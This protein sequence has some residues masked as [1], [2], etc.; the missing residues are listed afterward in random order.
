M[1][2]TLSRR[3]IWYGRELFGVVFKCRIRIWFLDGASA[4]LQRSFIIC[5]TACRSF[6][7]VN[8]D[9]KTDPVRPFKYSA[10]L[11]IKFLEWKHIE[12]SRL[13]N[14]GE[15]FSNLHRSWGQE[16]VYQSYASEARKPYLNVKSYICKNNEVHLRTVQLVLNWKECWL[17]FCSSF[18][19]K[20]MIVIRVHI[21]K[22][23]RTDV[24]HKITV[25][26][27]VYFM[28]ILLMPHCSSCFLEMCLNCIWNVK[29]GRMWVHLQTLSL[30]KMCFL[31]VIPILQSLLITRQT[32]DVPFPFIIWSQC[33]YWVLLYMAWQLL[34]LHFQ[35]LHH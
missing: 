21:V 31:W 26:F 32:A 6:S 20:I 18:H 34:S 33:G 10:I 3:R 17:L 1:F 30:V 19:L 23:S 7:E 28:F 24:V 4:C 14:S 11:K 22:Q 5:C 35:L 13:T 16:V 15:L 29:W 8:E 25:I 27:S 12:N 2:W 9:I